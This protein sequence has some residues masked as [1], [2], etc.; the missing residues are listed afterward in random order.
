MLASL[1]DKS[2]KSQRKELDSQHV[3]NI[4]NFLRATHFWPS[5]I[6]FKRKV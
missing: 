4:E 6:H 3:Q 2:R 1:I 5:L